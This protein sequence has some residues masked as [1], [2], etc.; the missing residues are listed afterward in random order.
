MA[1]ERKLV[2]NSIQ[3]NKK[4]NCS[5]KVR[6]ISFI[7]PQYST[8][9]YNVNFGYIKR[10]TIVSHTVCLLNYGP[11]ET[12]VF[13]D[14]DKKSLKNSGF[15]LKIQKAYMDIGKTTSLLVIFNPTRSLYPEVDI[16]VQHT[17]Y[18]VVCLFTFVYCVFNLM[19]FLQ[20]RGG[21]N[22]PLQIEGIVTLPQLSTDV[23]T[24]NFGKV[25]LGQCMLKTLI[26]ENK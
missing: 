13:I 22:I 17:V 7:P 12:T 24:L 11:K 21:L 5:K 6:P 2:D 9:P 16:F 20:V 15:V 25:Q 1:L 3:N 23:S 19:F 10:D 26:L 18:L 4:N 14:Q 8:V